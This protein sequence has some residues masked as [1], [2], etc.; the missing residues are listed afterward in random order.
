MN[1]RKAF[2]RVTLSAVLVAL[3]SIVGAASLASGAALW[4]S[5]AAFQ[6]RVARDETVRRAGLPHPVGFRDSDERGLLV[7]TW[8]NG[9]GPYTF[10]LDTGAGATIL[11]R[12]VAAEAR[13]PADGN[14]TLQI[15]GLSGAPT[16]SA[17]RAFVNSFAVGERD[18]LLPARGLAVVADGL[19]EDLDG[20][21]DPT[22]VFSPLGYVI[23]F[24]AKTLSAFDP[25][26][27]PLR[28][29]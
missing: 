16:R 28:N 21:L 5:F 19:P 13:V 18:N 27:N 17:R 6:R 3:L 2:A 23:D 26:A 10:A 4:R 22:E 9:A 7:R 20:I 12:R 8:V 29:A 15:G 14:R 25:R 1:G 24:P 11:S